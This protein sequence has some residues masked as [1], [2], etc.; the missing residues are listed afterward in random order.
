MLKQVPVRVDGEL[1]VV[2]F[3]GA[4]DR[5]PVQV[6]EHSRGRAEEDDRRIRFQAIDVLGDDLALVESREHPVEREDQPAL[7]DD[8]LDLSDHFAQ[9]V[10]G[11]TWKGRLGQLDLGEVH[12]SLVDCDDGVGFHLHRAH[13]WL[14]RTLGVESNG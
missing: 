5:V 9:L 14:G 12:Q 1:E 7:G 10:V 8:V 3:D 2:V 11:E 6:D 13:R 4:P